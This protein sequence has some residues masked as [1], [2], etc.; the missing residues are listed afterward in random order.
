[1]GPVGR[2]TDHIAVEDD[3]E[4]EDVEED[5]RLER[6][7][8]LVVALRRQRVDVGAVVERQLQRHHVQV[9]H[10][11]LLHHLDVH[12]RVVEALACLQCPKPQSPDTQPPAIGQ[13]SVSSLS[14][15]KL[16]LGDGGLPPT[17]GSRPQD[18]G[19]LPEDV[20]GTVVTSVKPNETNVTD[21]V[22]L[23]AISKL[24][25]P[26]S[27]T[28]DSSL[29]RVQLGAIKARKEIRILEYTDLADESYDSRGAEGKAIQK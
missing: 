25:A 19:R 24:H 6:Q 7:V 29:F 18:G 4:G 16:R 9:Q 11:L 8:G 1:M 3:A 26:F 15:R 13:F 17:G 12:V 28:I 20:R 21:C 5:G 14:L 2:H 10:A 27:F 23:S 22:L